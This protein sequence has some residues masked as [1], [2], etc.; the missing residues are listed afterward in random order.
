L[1]TLIP[2]AALL[3]F[4]GHTAA[5]TMEAE[6]AEAA[7]AAAAAQS[8]SE[9]REAEVARKLEEAERKMA[10]AARQI[11]A[12][13]SER[14]PQLQDL[15]R[16]IEIINDGRP[17]LGVNIGDDES[18][19]PVEGVRVVGVTP[20]SA[21][22]DAGLRT[23]DIITA[24]NGESMSAAASGDATRR[25]LDFMDGV[26]EGDTLQVEYLRDGKVGTV[27]VEPRAVE[28][29]AYAFRGFPKDFSMPS[30]PDVHVAPG[31]PDKFHDTFTFAWSGNVWA[32]MELVELNEGLGRYFGA[33]T[34]VLV[35]SAPESDALQLED[36]DVIQKI[37]GREPTSVRHAMRILGSYQP[38]ETLKI[39]ILRD[40]KRRTLD[41][42]I[43]DDRSSMMFE[44]HAPVRP[45]V[46]PRPAAAP[47]PAPHREKT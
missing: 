29:R 34:G 25:I 38:G 37:D 32:D 36:G 27:E 17:R 5:Q 2:V 14:L 30:M 1:K 24:I 26:E 16:R 15:E 21:A 45:A 4:A 9:S 46:A 39:E 40:R 35:V 22:E 20:G 12:L 28:M 10:E 31:V 43:P 18:D 41:V 3:L 44:G 47:R 42:E 19:G 6:R 33:D 23:G 8:A 7:R 13:T 11:A